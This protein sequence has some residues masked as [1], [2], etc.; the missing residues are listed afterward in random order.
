MEIGNIDYEATFQLAFGE[1]ASALLRTHSRL[2]GRE[3][4]VSYISPSP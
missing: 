2:P 4:K 3:G 1:G